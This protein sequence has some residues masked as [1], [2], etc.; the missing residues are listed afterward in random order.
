MIAHQVGIMLFGEKKDGVPAGA[1]K[2]NLDEMMAMT[3]AR[4]EN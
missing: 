1:R 4:W 3:G 2:A